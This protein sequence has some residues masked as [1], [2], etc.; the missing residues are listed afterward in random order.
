[1]DSNHS[2]ME[3][4]IEASQFHHLDGRLE[5]R[6]LRLGVDARYVHPQKCELSSV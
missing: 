3:L 6:G 1:M 2:L 4:A 5:I